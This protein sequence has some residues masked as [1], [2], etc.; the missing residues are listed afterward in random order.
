[1]NPLKIPR[2]LRAMGLRC[3]RPGAATAL[4]ADSCTDECA[5]SG[6]KQGRDETR[7]LAAKR[8]TFVPTWSDQGLNASFAC[9]LPW[10]GYGEPHPSD[11]KLP[12]NNEVAERV[13]SSVGRATGRSARV[14]AHTPAS[15]VRHRMPI[16]LG[17]IL[18]A[19]HKKHGITT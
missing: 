19:A 11:Q 16:A 7:E 8:R 3:A 6:G 10:S 15:H 13:T 2:D 17:V 1:M 5:L 18:Q 14:L 9:P 4:R 12:P